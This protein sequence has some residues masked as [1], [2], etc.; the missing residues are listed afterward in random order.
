MFFMLTLCLS[1]N[2]SEIY[3]QAMVRLDSK[4]APGVQVETLAPYSGRPML[5][6]FFMPK[7]RWCQRQHKTLK[8]MQANCPS[9]Q[10]VM[11]GVQGSKRHLKQE[12]KREKNT[13]PAYIASPAIVKA[14]GAKSPVPMMLM[15]N[16]QGQLVF[17]TQGY[18][19]QE[20]LAK[21]F[22]ETGLDICQA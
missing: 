19:P 9:L 6:S 21:L 1:V 4:D 10:P 14:I 7:C 18:T 15:F 22:Y 11:L 16:G 8:Q 13:F 12:L 20:K 17:K 3:Q 5:V 2:A